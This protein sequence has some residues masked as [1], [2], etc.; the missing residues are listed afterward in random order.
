M[1][2][3]DIDPSK[4]AEPPKPVHIGG[5]SLVDRLL[6][7][8]KKILVAFI[9]IAVI[10]SAVFGARAC[11]HNK[12]AR[13]TEKVAAVFEAG[14][15]PMANP[16]KPVDPVKNPGFA[17]AKERAEKMLEEIAKQGTSVP[18]AVR[19]SLLMDAGKTDEAIAAYRQCEVGTTVD[20]VLCREGLGLALETKALAQADAAAKQA[21]LQ[22][23]LEVFS[24][25]QPIEDGARRVYA[26]YHQARIQLLLGKKAEGKQLLE[27]A[28]KL[29][30]PRDLE[31]QIE[32]RLSTLGAA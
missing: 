31:E 28:K 24:R 2:D 21:G 4:P 11:K 16:D 9:V 17:T 13:E 1:A 5:E 3:K 32:L 8:I 27:D 12:Q 10:V 6:P 29:Q 14:K 22:E 23:A 18:D 30:P 19:G 15:G 25:M 7:H 26:I 20:H